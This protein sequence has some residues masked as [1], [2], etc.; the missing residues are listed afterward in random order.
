MACKSAE[1]FIKAEWET[2]MRSYLPN[3]TEQEQRDLND[4]VETL[5]IVQRAIVTEETTQPGNG[6]AGDLIKAVANLTAVSE[7][8]CHPFGGKC[9]RCEALAAIKACAE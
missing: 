5:A 4:A 8:Y 9:F 1:R 7:C 6:V 2:R 3:P